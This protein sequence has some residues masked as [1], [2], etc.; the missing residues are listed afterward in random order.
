MVTPKLKKKHQFVLFTKQSFLPCGPKEAKSDYLRSWFR[1]SSC[2]GETPQNEVGKGNNSKLDNFLKI[3]QQD[4]KRASTF[5][6][7]K[8]ANLNF[9]RFERKIFDFFFF[10]LAS[11]NN[12][13]ICYCLFD[14]ESASCFTQKNN[15]T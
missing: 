12:F 3:L 5:E 11:R 2:R 8:S 13:R 1:T 7:D 9:E 14:E 10:L 6:M 4:K 15:I